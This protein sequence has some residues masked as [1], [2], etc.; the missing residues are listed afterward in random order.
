MPFVVSRLSSLTADLGEGPQWDEESQSLWMMD[1]RKGEIYQIDTSGE[2]HLRYRGNPPC[3]SYSL[4]RE[5][6]I[7]IAEKDDLVTITPTGERKIVASLPQSHPNLRFNDG[8][9]LA[10][11]SF[12]VGSMHLL[13]AAGEAPLGGV[14]RLTCEGDFKT[15]APGLGVANGPCISPLDGRF[16]ICDSTA[17]EI[18]SYAF[19]KAGNL[20][21]RQ[22]F[23]STE[24]FHSSPDG[25]AFDDQGGLWTA[26][27]HGGAVLRYAPDGSVSE[28]I[29]LPLSH[30]T[31]VSFGGPNMDDLF[32]TSIS[33]SGRLKAEGPMDGAIL[34]LSGLGYRGFARPR[35]SLKGQ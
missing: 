24:A 18:Y 20:T 12:V 11:G 29:P 31:A 22:L 21:D 4:L 25:C 5:G 10:D 17:K 27:V 15:L 26:L 2:A 13:R 30:P 35:F 19:D 7:L 28:H 9:C 23:A 16:Y 14:Y 33:D 8:A 34:R 6:G 3:G 1:C 32:V